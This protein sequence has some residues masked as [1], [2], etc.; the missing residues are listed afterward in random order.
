MELL[1]L[2]VKH[3]R[4]GVGTITPTIGSRITVT[5]PGDIVK[6]FVYPTAFEKFIQAEDPGVQASILAD[7]SSAKQAREEE[8]AHK[9]APEQLSSSEN[10]ASKKRT[11]KPLD[12]M[13]APDYHAEMLAREPIFT[14]QQVEDLFSIRISGFGRG[15]NPT[16]D[17][18][19]L[20]SSI[21]K[22]RDSFVYHDKWLENGDYLYSGEG[23]SG[24]QTMTRGNLAIRDAALNGKKL[25]LLIR[26]SAKE[27]YYQGTSSLVDYFLQDEE[28]DS[29][30]L[31]REY[32]FQLRKSQ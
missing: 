11:S 19:V 5:F 15:I 9:P 10:A 1:N 30:H 8:A 18:V 16:K 13:F 25:H 12:E 23:K 29:G 32:K 6:E 14:Y 22:A 17:A 4:F 28:D 21:K 20:I 27:Y 7:I 2:K 24:D 3:I 31:R 26:F